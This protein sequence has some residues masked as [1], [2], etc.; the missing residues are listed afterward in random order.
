MFAI[1]ITDVLMFEFQNN[2]FNLSTGRLVSPRCCSSCDSLIFC[3]RTLWRAVAQEWAI[4]IVDTEED[5][6]MPGINMDGIE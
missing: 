2:D 3:S 6:P 1:P 5:A 4:K